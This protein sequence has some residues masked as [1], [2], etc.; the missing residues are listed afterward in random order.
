M[1]SKRVFNA[2]AVRSFHAAIV[3]TAPKAFSTE[4][5]APKVKIPKVKA[6][7][8]PKAPKEVKE[9]KVKVPKQKI[10]K[11]SVSIK[12]ADGV[13][14]CHLIFCKRYNSPPTF[15]QQY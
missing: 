2:P 5:A 14:C 9:P 13:R 3:T 1:L 15:T 7:K 12:V 10:V 4:A 6:P 11:E 8:E